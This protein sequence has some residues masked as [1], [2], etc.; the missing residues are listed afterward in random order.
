MA[1]GTAQHEEM[2]DGV[3]VR[4]FVERI[5]QRSGDVAYSLGNNPYYCMGAYR[6]HQ[7]FEGNQYN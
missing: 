7:R 6:I 1:H 3:H 5:E 2:E 4:T